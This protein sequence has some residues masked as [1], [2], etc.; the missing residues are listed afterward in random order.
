MQSDSQ[1]HPT[2]PEPPLAAEAAR[3]VAN[4][5]RILARAASPQAGRAVGRPRNVRRNSSHSGIPS[6]DLADTLTT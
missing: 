1:T 6:P 3:Q 4:D 2:I 5:F